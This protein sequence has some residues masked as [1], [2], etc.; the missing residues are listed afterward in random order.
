M[1]TFEQLWRYE[2][3]RQQELDQ[4]IFDDAHANRKALE[5]G[6]DLRDQLLWRAH[7]LAKT[8]GGEQ[9][10][11]KARQVM[12]MALGLLGALGL[13]IGVSAGLASLGDSAR[14]LNLLWALG[15]LLLVPT[16]ALVMWLVLMVSASGSGGWLGHWWQWLVGRLL[17]T[18]QN[19][20]VWQGWLRLSANAQT[21][22]WWLALA[23]HGM[24]LAIITGVLIAMVMAFS[25]R[26]YTF[27]WETTWLGEDVFVR[28]AQFIGWLPELMGFQAPDDQ[29]IR[30]SGNVAVDT[31]AARMAWASWLVGAVF[32]FGWLPR[33]I[34]VGISAFVLRQRYK[35][36]QLDCDDAYALSVRAKL[37]RL[38]NPHQVDGPDGAPDQWQQLVGIEPAQAQSEAAWLAFELQ[39]QAQAQQALSASARPIPAADDRE[40]RQQATSLLQ[41]LL[42]RRLLIVLDARQ[43]PDRGAIRALLGFGAL[44][45]QTRVL[46][47]H[48]SDARARGAAWQERLNQAGVTRAFVQ[49]SQAMDWLSGADPEQGK[50]IGSHAN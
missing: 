27:V 50:E 34:L 21:E 9:A 5:M 15:S 45:V 31:S 25:L 49:L 13:L 29:T 1:Q 17:K 26:H 24:W 22:R 33:L 46:L 43:T 19:R 48:A 2:T 35:R 47:L 42:P 12:R 39:P 6:Q 41:Q 32:V 23:T 8:H 3:V 28:V 37:A 30:A 20:A 44:A 10:Q 16:L 14:A 18:R 4:Q 7:E 40:S 11:S 38:Q 36:Y